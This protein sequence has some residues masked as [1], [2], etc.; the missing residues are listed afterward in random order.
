MDSNNHN[1]APRVLAVGAAGK[2]A[3]HVIPALA[4]RGATVRALVRQEAEGEAARRAGAA[5]IAIGDLTDARS[6]AAG[7]SGIDAAFYIA[8]AF[9]PDEAGIGKRFVAAAVDAGVRRIVFSSVIHPVISSLVNHAA[10]APVEEAILDSGLDYTFLHPALYFQN[11]QAS[12]DTVV[13]SGTLA[14]PWS[15]DTRFSRVDYRDVAEVAAIAL[16]EDRLLYGTFELCAEGWLNR[17]DVAGLIGDVLGRE[18]RAARIDPATLGPE[19][20]PMR[21]MFAHYDHAGLRGNPLSLRAIL[22]REPRRLRAF[23]EELAQS[24]KEKQP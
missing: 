10:K 24:Q 21:P 4:S 3:G 6:I 15:C 16:T 7:L 11:Y 1:N 19:A 8:P 22:G 5:E 23:F 20:D 9:I 17:H 2:F 18:I 14:E 13:K 12:W